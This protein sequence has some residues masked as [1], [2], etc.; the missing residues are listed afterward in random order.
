MVAR[1]YYVAGYGAQRGPA[2]QQQVKGIGRLK[3]Q[4]THMHTENK[5]N[6]VEVLDHKKR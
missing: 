6:G 5:C 2:V 1:L 3:A 4:Y